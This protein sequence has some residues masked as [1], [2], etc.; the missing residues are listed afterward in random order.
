MYEKTECSS[1]NKTCIKYLN[2]KISKKISFVSYKYYATIP[3]NLK[4]ST[5]I[6]FYINSTGSIY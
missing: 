5:V 3:F 2:F 1:P 6:D 4:L